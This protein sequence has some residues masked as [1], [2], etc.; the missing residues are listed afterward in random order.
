MSVVTI[1][2]LI[3]GLAAERMKSD[4]SSLASHKKVGLFGL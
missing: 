4:G 1:V 2:T 3:D